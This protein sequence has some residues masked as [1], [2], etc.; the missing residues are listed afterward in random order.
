VFRQS[1]QPCWESGPECCV[2]DSE[3][4]MVCQHVVGEL[5]D[6]T[7]TGLTGH[8]ASSLLV[9]EDL[10]DGVGNLPVRLRLLHDKTGHTVF[11]GFGGATAVACNL[12]YTT[13]GCL[14][15]NDSEALLFE[16]TPS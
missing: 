7:V 3:A 6:G 9:S 8:L 10:A 14:Y 16:T 12:G 15:E 5:T 13:G 4:K 1:L 2:I 11:D